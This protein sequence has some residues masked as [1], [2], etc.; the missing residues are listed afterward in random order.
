MSVCSVPEPSE[1]QHCRYCGDAIPA[2]ARRPREFC[3]DAH[4]KAAA[5]GS[6]MSRTAAGEAVGEFFLANRVPAAARINGQIESSV[7][8]N[9]FGRGYRWPDAKANGN[10]VQIAAAVDAELGVGGQA[11]VSPDG[12]AVTIVPS[13]NRSRVVR[14]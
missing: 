1:Q 3:S 9:L 2:G 14:A 12:V 11:V 8:V 7:P 13:R 4:R 10:A 6:R 5:R